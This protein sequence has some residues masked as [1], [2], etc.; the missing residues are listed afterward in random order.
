ME[1]DNR[2][3]EAP[4]INKQIPLF[5]GVGRFAAEREEDQYNPILGYPALPIIGRYGGGGYELNDVLMAMS[6]PC[7]IVGGRVECE[8]QPVALPERIIELLT[9][10]PEKIVH[11]RPP[12]RN[13]K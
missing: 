5:G 7:R 2:L 8:E 10:I 9:T 4:F 3:L 13:K 11:N 6:Y 12:K 1:A